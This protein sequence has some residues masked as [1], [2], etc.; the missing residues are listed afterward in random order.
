MPDTI[1]RQEAD[2]I[3][4]TPAA[5]LKA[6]AIVYVGTICGQVTNDVVANA[7]GALRI[8]GVVRM[9]KASATVFAAG[10]AVNYDT[11]SKLSVTTGGAGKAGSAA[12]AAPAGQ[13]YVDVILNM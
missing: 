7:L 6:G 8:K 3:D 5:D 2:L 12:A 11:A 13:L 10:A 9:T 4:I 1:F